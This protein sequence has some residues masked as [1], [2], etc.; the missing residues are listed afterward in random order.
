MPLYTYQC[1]DCTLI[2]ERR[3][4]MEDRNQQQKCDA[5]GGYLSRKLDKPGM[6][7]SPTRNNGYSF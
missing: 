4:A 7:W 1:K 3:V 6:V 5:C 2:I